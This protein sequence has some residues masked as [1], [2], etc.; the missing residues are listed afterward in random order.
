MKKLFSMF[1]ALIILST[2]AFAQTATPQTK[3]KPAATTQKTPV[4]KKDGTP[5]KR[6]KEN[7]VQPAVKTKK[8]GTPDKR[9]KENKPPASATKPSAGTPAKDAKQ[10][11][12]TK[13]TEP[14]K[15]PN[16]K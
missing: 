11:V 5:D 10:P 9:Y 7:K 13:K 16:G 6:Y 12:K 15:K 14:A 1:A 4:V 8:D 3:A 2:A